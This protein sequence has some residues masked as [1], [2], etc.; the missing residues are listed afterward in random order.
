MLYKPLYDS[1]DHEQLLEVIPRPL[2]YAIMSLAV[3]IQH[4]DYETDHKSKQ[5]Q[6]QQYFDEALSALKNVGQSQK[7]KSLV[8]IESSITK[9][10]VY[11]I[12]ALQ[13]HSIG[14]FS[15]AG[16]FCAIAASMAIDQ[17]LH[18]ISE[19]DNHAETQVKSRLWW[20]I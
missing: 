12:L 19:I 13:Q 5:D 7:V 11:T 8:E 20:T 10:Q 18:R 15:Q 17:S 9:C 6:A 16:I 14:A 1:L 3:L 4:G 2:V